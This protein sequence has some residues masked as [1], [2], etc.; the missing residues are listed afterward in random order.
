MSTYTSATDADRRA[1]LDEIGAMSIEQL[2]AD[3]PGA[4]RLDRPLALP[5]GMAEQEVY[6]HLKELASRNVSART[7]SASSAPAC[8]TTTCRR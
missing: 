1:M 8:T 7:R 6:E 4:L 3:I 5:A 2:F